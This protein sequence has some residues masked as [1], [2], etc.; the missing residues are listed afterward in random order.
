MQKPLNNF[1]YPDLKPED[2]RLGSSPIIT[3][4]LRADGDWRS[5]LPPFEDQLI[6]G[7]EASDCYVEASQHA[8]ATII[9]ERFGIKDKNFSARYNA[10]LSNGTEGGGSPTEGA[11]SIRHDGLIDDDLFNFLGVGSWD[12]YHSWKGV[13]EQKLRTKGK[14]WL[15][16]F[17]PKWDI[18]FE[19][20]NS[21]KDKIT[22]LRS[23]LRFSPVP[24]SVNGNYWY[25]N[26]DG[27]YEKPKGSNDTHFVLAVYLDEK[28][29]TTILD[30]YKPYIKVL[31]PNYDSDFGLRWT[32]DKNIDMPLNAG[33]INT[34]KSIL[35]AN[36]IETLL[37]YLF[38][39]LFSMENIQTPQG[40]K[41]LE[42]TMNNLGKDIS[43]SQ[44]QFGCAESVC[45][46]L[47]LAFG[48]TWK[49]LSTR[50]M[51]DHFMISPY[52]IKVTE[53]LPGDIIL[54]PTGYG[55]TGNIEHGHVGCVVDKELIASN[56]SYT[57]KLSL[58]YNLKSWKERY[59]V[60]G[61]YPVLFYR[62]IQ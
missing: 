10:L 6:N 7:V 46:L 53:P 62:R 11:Q 25:P 5:Y 40:R 20:E 48:D 52:Y 1:I 44:N 17:R 54:S 35:S 22:K 14:A 45:T 56:D 34:V 16:S 61:G 50:E 26:A 42:V 4:E 36:Q 38:D 28:N 19:R 47:H 60:L 3:P 15:Q 23:A 27:Q 39:K 57:S 8:I 30:T 55:T 37:N 9:S 24:M 59:G 13:D 21:V 12:E 29:R 43:P 2:F 49:T 41:L 33:I 31:A 18:V 58:S 51:Y 32:V